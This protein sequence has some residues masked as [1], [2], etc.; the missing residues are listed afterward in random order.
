MK[1]FYTDVSTKGN[2]ILHRGYDELGRRVKESVSFRPT[3]FVPTKKPNQNTWKTIEGIDVSPVDF[4]NTYEAREFVEKYTDVEGFKVYGQIDAQYQFIAETYGSDGELEYDSS[5]VRV[6]S[7]DIECE[8]EDGFPTPEDPEERINVI[9]VN[10]S[11]KTYTFALG[12]AKIDGVRVECFDDEARMLHRFL[13]VWEDLDPDILTGWNVVFFDVPYLYRRIE[14]VLGRKVAQRLSPWQDVRERKGAINVMGKQSI[15]Y[16]IVGISI[17]DYQDLYKKFTFTPQ[18][19]YKL[20]YIASQELGEGKMSYEEYDSMTEFY[21][22]DFQRFVEYNIRDVDLVVRLEDKLRLIELS[23]GL[24]YSARGN[25]SDVFT[26]VRMWDSIIYN[27]LRTK[28]IAIPPKTDNDKNIQFEGAYVKDPHVGLHEWVVSFDLDSLYPHLIMQYNLSPETIVDRKIKDISVDDLIS[29]GSNTLLEEALDEAKSRGLSVAANGTMYR[30]D[31]RG[32]LPELMDTMYAQRKGYK[33]KMLDIKAWLKNN[34]DADSEEIAKAK[35]GISKYNNFQMVRKVQLNSA[36]GAL[37]NQ[38]CRY[39]NLDMAEAI[40]VSGQLSIRWVEERLNKFLSRVCG[41]KGDYIIG[42]DTDSVYVKTGCIVEKM[43]GTGKSRKETIMFIDKCC[44]DVILPK[45]D[46]WYEELSARMNAYE[47]RMS[48]KRECISSKGIWKAKKKYM[49]AVHLGEDNVYSETPDLKIMGIETVRSSTPS[50]VRKKLKEAINLI[51]TRDE[52]S[53]RSFVEKFREEFLTLPVE[54]VSFPRSCNGMGK[55]ADAASIYKK[56]TP[57]AVKG[58]LIYNHLIRKKSLDRK[59][60]LIREADKI[61]FVYLK[62]PNPINQ[63]VISF[64]GRLPDEFNLTNHID[65]ELQFTKSFV[66]PL[67]TILDTIG[68][69]LED[70]GSL[71]DL[72]A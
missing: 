54:Q 3:L 46:L 7:I 48:M 64:P 42:A 45:I 31:I 12:E 26:Q 59:H 70:T 37:G 43:L 17:L 52:G 47:N 24:A 8:S 38:Y 34:P 58:S 44:R 50:I 28:R 18:E 71:S 55:Y 30:R 22:N 61:K 62:E 4:E 15:A 25:F 39:Y 11:G 20:E 29:V 68:W 40:T 57:I 21:R 5:L 49:L 10:M 69:K 63:K 67:T 35:K 16:Y 72:F 19:S 23:Q 65:H 60:Q 33:K 53:L 27:Y 66:E 56:A 6:A 13:D 32:F 36:F 2:R 41:G 1:P 14:R 51:M 9:T